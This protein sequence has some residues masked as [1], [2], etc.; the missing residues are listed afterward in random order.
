MDPNLAGLRRARLSKV[1]TCLTGRQA[2]QDQPA[3]QLAHVPADSYD[4][5]AANGEDLKVVQ[6]RL[7]HGPV[8]IALFLSAIVTFVLKSSDANH[9]CHRP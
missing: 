2:C 3:D 6:K 8:T 5:N 9:S 7:R 4:L 1:M